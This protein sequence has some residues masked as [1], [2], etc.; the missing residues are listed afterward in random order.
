MNYTN[1][2]KKDGS[3]LKRPLFTSLNVSNLIS[4]AKIEEKNDKKK[5]AF[6]FV[7]TIIGLLVTGL[8]ISI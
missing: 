4:S 8:I 3:N 2:Q 6:I 7:S 5:T 1:L